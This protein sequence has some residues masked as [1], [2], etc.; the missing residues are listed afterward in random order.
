MSD[1]DVPVTTESED[2]ARSSGN[3]QSANG[4]GGRHISK[5]LSDAE[6]QKLVALDEALQKF[7]AQ[8]RWSDV[9]KTTLEKADLNAFESSA[10]F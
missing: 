4:N 7:Q 6:R 9:I 3:H 1:N 2:E 5:E 8:K 10:P